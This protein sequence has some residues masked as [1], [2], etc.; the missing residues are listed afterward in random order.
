MITINCSPEY[1]T[2]TCN[3]KEYS[4]RY[5]KET[6]DQLETI[7]TTA[8]AT[9]V[10]AEYKKIC[11][12]FMKVAEPSEAQIISSM[13]PGVVFDEGTG[14]YYFEHNGV[15]STVPMPSRLV[16][17]LKEAVEKDLPTTPWVKFWL[18]LLRNPNIRSAGQASRFANQVVEY[19]TRTFVS[20]SLLEKFTEKGYT[21]EI[22]TELATVPQ[23][24]LT[25]EGLIC[26]K[27]V[28][29]PLY[30]RTYYK[31][32]LDENGERKQVLRD[33]VTKSIDENTG[34]ISTD[35]KYSE[36][37][38]FEPYIQR[39]SGDEFRMG[40]DKNAPLGHVISVGNEMWLDKWSQVNCD[41]DASAVKG[42]HT[43]NQDY[44]R[45]YEHDTNVT[46][47]AFVDPAD[48]GAVACYDDV[49]RV[50]ALF[51]HSIKDR[52][53]DNR[54]MYHSSTY[55]AKKDAEWEEMKKEA[56]ARFQEK[57]AKAE[58]VHAEMSAL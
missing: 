13:I 8:E 44:I 56:A 31:Y 2:G 5:S 30:D 34:A 55:A 49:L 18:R 9:D 46:L 57:Q 37:W 52:E 7:K 39:T 38:I 16:D 47:N 20:P 42:I 22:A 27:K 26:T 33:G 15:R 4:V 3:G 43:G 28:V 25:M 24:P 11:E 36:S 45:G 35:V 54:N 58:A 6:L 48:I 41:P 14:H 12:E 23:T 40:N 21:K 29:A 32:V 50:K 10:V 17:K 53:D 1:I 19:I 51:P